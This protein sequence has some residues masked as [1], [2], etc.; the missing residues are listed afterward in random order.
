[1]K[2]IYVSGQEGCNYYYNLEE[3]EFVV[4]K[5][6]KR[7]MVT[8]YLEFAI[9]SCICCAVIYC[10]HSGLVNSWIGIAD[11]II[12]RCIVMAWSIVMIKCLY[13]NPFY[14]GDRK[15]RECNDNELS[16]LRK[17]KP[18]NDINAMITGGKFTLIVLGV[19]AA[20]LTCAY[21]FAGGAVVGMLSF[22]S[23]LLLFSILDWFQQDKLKAVRRALMKL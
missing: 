12:S 19:F 22:V 5:H 15:F 18:L 20:V 3:K 7:D 10:L 23:I 13:A 16:A 9:V 21:L 17:N 14:W 1:M 4:R 8:S 2:Y 11:G 6:Y